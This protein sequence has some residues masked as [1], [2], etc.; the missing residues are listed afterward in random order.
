MG[1]S[2]GEVGLPLWLALAQAKASAPL[3]PLPSGGHAAAP[4]GCA[5]ELRWSAIGSQQGLHRDVL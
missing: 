1:A 4:K 5:L 2:P 3:N